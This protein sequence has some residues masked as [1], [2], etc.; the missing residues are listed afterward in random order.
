M[1]GDEFTTAT[2]RAL[3]ESLGPDEGTRDRVIKGL[4]DGSWVVVPRSQVDGLP[5]LAV[6]SGESRA[7]AVPQSH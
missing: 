3:I 4:I 1:K 5:S 7:T 2:F 6:L